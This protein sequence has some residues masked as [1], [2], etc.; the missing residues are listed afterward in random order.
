M[1]P[2]ETSDREQIVDLLARLAHATDPGT[3]DDYAACFTEDAVMMLP[4]GDPVNGLADIL[5]S[6]KAR[7][8][9][10]RAG[11]TSRTRHVITTTAVALGGDAATSTTYIVFYGMEGGPTVRALMVYNDRFRRTAQGW[12]LSE[13]KATPG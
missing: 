9:A 2:G 5:A 1:T 4:G 11:P 7:R 13:R 8:A 6:S 12:R 3:L 10:D